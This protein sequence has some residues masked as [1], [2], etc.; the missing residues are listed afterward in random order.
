MGGAENGDALG[1]SRVLF[2]NRAAL[3]ASED[4]QYVYLWTALCLQHLSL[5]ISICYLR[6]LAVFR[7]TLIH[8][9]LVAKEGGVALL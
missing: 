6:H 8:W 4:G 5:L 9:Q 1:N 7:G 2:T 3:I